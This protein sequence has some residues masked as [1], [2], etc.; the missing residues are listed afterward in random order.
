MANKYKLITGNARELNTQLE[1][2]GTAGWG[3]GSASPTHP[4]RC[5]NGY[6]AATDNSQRDP[7]ATRSANQVI[8]VRTLR[9]RA[10]LPKMHHT[11]PY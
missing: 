1:I 4:A 11:G 3:H 9:R 8:S 10:A 5:G 7:R 2:E 6:T